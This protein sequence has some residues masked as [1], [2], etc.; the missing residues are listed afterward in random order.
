MVEILR[1]SPSIGK[2]GRISKQPVYTEV[3]SIVDFQP[4]EL[5]IFLLMR[6]DL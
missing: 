5:S 3:T 6:V 4:R 1:V 2:S